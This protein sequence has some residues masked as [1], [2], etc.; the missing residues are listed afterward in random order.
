MNVIASASV[1]TKSAC[2]ASV[3]DS[4]IASSSNPTKFTLAF[5][6]VFSVEASSVSASN[7]TWL[8][9]ASLILNVSAS[10]AFVPQ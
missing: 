8:D 4:V 2:A 7:K 9:T 5:S 10:D 3:V 6:V 1:P